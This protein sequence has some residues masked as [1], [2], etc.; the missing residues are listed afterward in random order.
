[1][2]VG[3]ITNVIPASELPVMT[4]EEYLSNVNTLTVDGTGKL[5]QLPRGAM[6]NLITTVVQ[7]GDKGD[8]GTAGVKGDKGDK[9]DKR[10]KL[11]EERKKEK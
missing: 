1:M 6:F 5:K 2:A 4:E 9:G 11:K 3:N 7:K 8:T 10:R